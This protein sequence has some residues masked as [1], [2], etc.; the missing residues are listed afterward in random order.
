MDNVRELVTPDATYVSLSLNN[1]SL[2]QIMPWCGTH[3]KAGPAAIVE[4]FINVGRHW[5]TRAFDIEAIFESGE[6]VQVNGTF[7]YQSRVLGITKSSPFAI[8]CKL[9]AQGKVTYMRF[10]EDTFGTASTFEKSGKKTYAA[11]PDG[12][13]VEL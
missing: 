7:T 6:N 13:E 8:W 11:D 3:D 10:M 9:N 2:K 5:E 4:T 12:H 1:P